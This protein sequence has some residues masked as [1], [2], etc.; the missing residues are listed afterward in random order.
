MAQLDLNDPLIN[1]MMKK[2]FNLILNDPYMGQ[3][4]AA[5][6][7]IE[8]NTWC[9]T[10]STDGKFFYFNREYMKT[11]TADEYGYVF[12]HELIHLMLDHIGRRGK[13]DP[14][15]WGMAIDYATNHIQRKE[16]L[17]TPPKGA[18]ILVDDKYDDDWTADM[19][20]A[21]LQARGVKST[22]QSFDQHLDAVDSDEEASQV[23]SRSASGGQAPVLSQEEMD[24]I[25]D[26]LRGQM[27]AMAQAAGSA[28]GFIQRIIGELSHP[29]MNWR[30]MLTATIQSAFKS[31]FSYN[32]L[33][34]RSQAIGVPLPGNI[35]EMAIKIACAIDTS[36]SMSDEMI[37]DLL[38]EILGIIAAYK[39]FEIWLWTFDGTV[40]NP[41]RFTPENVYELMEYVPEGG[42][43][44]TFSSCWEFMKN[45][46]MFFPEVDVDEIRPDRFVMFTD[47]YDGGDCGKS[48]EDWV[49][50]LFIIHSNDNFD[51]GF[52]K[53]AYYD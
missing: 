53:V 27:A 9:K 5:T 47:G 23:N 21:D 37:R 24:R 8:E 4:I 10:F 16:R 52:G 50:T 6:S 22:G 42:G 29:R 38:S 28:P 46:Q 3:F 51:A 20:Y 44:T 31:D 40:H 43:G 48:H 1:A 34:R 18:F 13:R 14:E 33:S 30:E 32:R 19:I 39:D 12:Y 25:R 7:M 15:L 49:D 26:Q 11:L 2:R 35:H 36:G 41:K 17:G 45:P